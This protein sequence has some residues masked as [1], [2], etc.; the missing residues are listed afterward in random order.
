MSVRNRRYNG[1]I[2]RGTFWIQVSLHCQNQWKQCLTFPWRA[3]IFY[4]INFYI[5]KHYQ[6]FIKK[7]S[8]GNRATVGIL[9]FHIPKPNTVSRKASFLF[10]KLLYMLGVSFCF[11]FFF[12]KCVLQFKGVYYKLLGIK[13]E[14][15]CIGC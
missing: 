11:D 10:L 4:V 12:P 9:V 14:W 13:I 8:S 6:C 5:I 1:I 7:E 2:I 15:L 3:T